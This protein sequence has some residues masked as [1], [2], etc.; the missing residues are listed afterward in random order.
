MLQLLQH[1]DR[2][3]KL[4][5]HKACPANISNAAI[6][7]DTGVQ[8][9]AAYIAGIIGRRR[10]GIC[11]HAAS[12]SRLCAASAIGWLRSSISLGL[13]LHLQHTPQQFANFL[14]LAHNNM[15]TKIT[16]NDAEHHRYIV[17]YHRYVGKRPA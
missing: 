9:L 14:L 15:N 1:K 7:N 13:F 2:Y 5:I 11:H 12:Q 10:P 16:E 4:A 6:N 3:Q 8:Q 17:A